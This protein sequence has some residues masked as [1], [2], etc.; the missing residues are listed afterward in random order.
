MNNQHCIFYDKNTADRRSSVEDSLRP[1]VLDSLGKNVFHT[2]YQS[3]IHMIILDEINLP[4]W[5]IQRFAHI[6]KHQFHQIGKWE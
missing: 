1:T 6:E 3:S 2:G 4:K 5:T